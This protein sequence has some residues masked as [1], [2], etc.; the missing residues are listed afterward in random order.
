[1]TLGQVIDKFIKNRELALSRDY[2]NKPISWALYETWKWANA[3]EKNR[4][5]DKEVEHE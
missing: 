1:M 4:N 2:I 3:Y 5:E